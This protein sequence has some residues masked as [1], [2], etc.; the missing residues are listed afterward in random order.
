MH[1][2]RWSFPLGLSTLSTVLLLWVFTIKELRFSS[3]VFA[4]VDTG[5]NVGEPPETL[6]H[7]T[8]RAVDDTPTSVPR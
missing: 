4:T 2:V 1:R 8:V 7:V 6:P 3:I 5:D